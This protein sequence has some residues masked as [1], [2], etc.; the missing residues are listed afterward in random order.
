MTATLSTYQRLRQ[1]V[2]PK[3]HYTYESSVCGDC[4]DDDDDSSSNGE[5]YTI[6][7]MKTQKGNRFYLYPSFN[8]SARLGT[9][10]KTPPRPLYPVKTTR[11]TFYRTLDGF[12]GRA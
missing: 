9:M 1:S 6:R 7:S 10:V 4:D 2:N 12:Q 5:V 3:A 11:F 8:L